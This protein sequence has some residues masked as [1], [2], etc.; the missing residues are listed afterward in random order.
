M[1]TIKAEDLKREINPGEEVLDL[2]SR[3]KSLERRLAEYK[4]DTGSLMSFFH[5]VY[6]EIEQIKPFKI[7]YRTP[8]K[9]AIVDSPISCVLHNTD[10]HMGA[11]QQ[12]DEI[13][14]FS[15][16]SPEILEKRIGYLDD[17]VLR[18]V[19]VLRSGYII[20]ELVILSTGDMIS[21]DIHEELKITNAF[22]SPVQVVRAAELFA[23]QV[24]FFAPHFETVRVEW[25]SEDNHSRLTRKPQASE[26]GLNSLN[27]LVGYIARSRLEAH[28]NVTFNIYP[29]F[30]STISVQT[31]RYL[32]THGHMGGTWLGY[33]Y[34][35]AERKAGKEALKRMRHNRGKFDKIIMGHWHSSMRHEVYWIGP[36]VQGTTTYDHQAGRDGGP[37]QAA[38]MVHPKYGEFNETNFGFEI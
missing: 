15:E 35:V 10:W 24:A 34:Y 23:K 6:E 33:P 7:E 9:R 16:F 37:A 32:L 28:R 27:Y 11:V 3:V 2:R 19:E 12:P 25:I 30:Q 29:M 13:E 36:S 4:A 14:G 38:W 22:P 20:P 5:D 8:R 17:K 18:W 21:G 31:R 26:A 1:K